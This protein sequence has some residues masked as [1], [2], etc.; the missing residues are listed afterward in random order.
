MDK[1]SATFQEKK[2]SVLSS[3]IYFVFIDFTLLS[4]FSDKRINSE[5]NLLTLLVDKGNSE[6]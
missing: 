4:L 3:F 2:L 1:L 6:N 5:E